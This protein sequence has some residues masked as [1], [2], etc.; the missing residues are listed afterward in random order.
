MPIRVTCPGCHS[1]FNVS[2]KFAG[3]KGPCPKCKAVILIPTENEQVVIHEPES[4]GPRNETGQAVLKP[5]SRTETRLTAIHIALIVAGTLLFLAGALMIRFMIDDKTAPPPV[6]LVVGALGLGW[7]MAF[8]GYTFL[9]DPDL[10]GFRGKELWARVG[11]CGLIYA[12]SWLWMP[13]M[14]YA[15]DGYGLGAWIA[16]C[17]GMLVM[18]GFTGMYSF[19]FDFA[20]GILHYGLFFGVSLLGRWLAGL[21]AFPGM[22]EQASTIS[23]TAMTIGHGDAPGVQLLGWLGQASMGLLI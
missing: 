4:F 6:L 15:F 23:T 3:K 20:N 5:I 14:N 11:I 7:L 22:L 8:T 1:R 17:I 18:G 21:G 10:G 19:D 13:L 9:R 16:A 2:D 12:A